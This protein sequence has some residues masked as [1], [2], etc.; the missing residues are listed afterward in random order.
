MAGTAVAKTIGAL[1][2]WH[3]HDQS[4]AGQSAGP[5]VGVRLPASRVGE[6][7]PPGY[8]ALCPVVPYRVLT[9]PADTSAAVRRDAGH[10]AAAGPGSGCGAQPW[11]R[12]SRKGAVRRQT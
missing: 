5:E 4:D 2:G 3:A 7:L 6:V 9:P 12:K 1:P 8:I 11:L 10:G